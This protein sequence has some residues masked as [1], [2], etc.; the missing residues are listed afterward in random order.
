[1]AEDEHAFGVDDVKR[2]QLLRR[3]T[4]NVELGRVV[5]VG[6]RAA[7]AVADAQFLDPHG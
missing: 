1:M 5:E 3:L 4:A 2:L 7:F 6:E